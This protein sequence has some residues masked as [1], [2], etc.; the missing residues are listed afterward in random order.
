MVL[1]LNGQS[2]RH[3]HV[4]QGLPNNGRFSNLREYFNP[5]YNRS[6]EWSGQKEVM[7]DSGGGTV[8]L[9]GDASALHRCG[10][11][12]NYQISVMISECARKHRVAMVQ[13][14]PVLG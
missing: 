9:S 7:C 6:R 2:D 8:A 3:R 14:S 13:S 4:N 12:P 1:R 11:R 10:E 5:L